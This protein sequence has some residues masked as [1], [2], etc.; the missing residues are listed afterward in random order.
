MD[1]S[2]GLRE[3]RRGNRLPKVICNSGFA[4]VL[5]FLAA[6]LGACVRRPEAPAPATAADPSTARHTRSGLVVG[7]PGRY[8]G[9]AWL[10]I[11]YA[12]PPVGALRW[13][14]PQ[15]PQSWAGT[16]DA[17]SFGSP[18]TQIASPLGGI[19]GSRPG[20]VV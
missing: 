7:M 8:G 19:E 2:S 18:C 9:H 14:A 11:P 5:T 6:G 1:N 17:I 3:A 16:R 15:P 20:Q 10:G 12:Q 4:I 13:R